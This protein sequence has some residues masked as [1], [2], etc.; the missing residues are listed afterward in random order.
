MATFAFEDYK[1]FANEEQPLKYEII[2]PINLH[3]L[4]YFSQMLKIDCKVHNYFISTDLITCT[5]SIT[6]N[7]HIL[8]IYLKILIF[9]LLVGTKVQ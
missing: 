7:E 8:L 3:F 9:A 5:A 4:S 6:K 2:F 1:T